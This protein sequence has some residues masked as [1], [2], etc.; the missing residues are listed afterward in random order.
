MGGFNID[1]CLITHFNC[2][3]DNN[4]SLN[5]KFFY[6]YQIIQYSSAPFHLTHSIS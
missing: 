6:K 3:S 2:H 5:I 4:G 1:L